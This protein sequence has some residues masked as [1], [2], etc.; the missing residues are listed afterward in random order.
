M[1]I[2]DSEGIPADSIRLTRYGLELTSLSA[3]HSND[4]ITLLLK[5]RGG[6]EE[7]TDETIDDMVS[8]VRTVLP[9]AQR[10]TDRQHAL[11]EQEFRLLAAG[12]PVP[13]PAPIPAAQPAPDPDPDPDPHNT[14][15]MVSHCGPL[16]LA[17]E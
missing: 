8:P 10:R 6:M 16:A 4:A 5:L 7:E 3:L 13:A 12:Y 15:E 11:S 1:L 9:L 17:Q 2:Q 14:E